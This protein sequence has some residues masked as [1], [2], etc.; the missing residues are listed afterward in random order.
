MTQVITLGWR[1]RLA[2]PTFGIAVLKAKLDTGARSS[3][4]HVENLTVDTENAAT[5]LSFDVRTGRRATAPVVACR[6]LATGRRPVTDSG[7]HATLRW[8]IRTDI[9]IG[10]HRFDID[11]NLT[12]RRHMLFPLLLGRTSLQ[13]RVHVDAGRSYTTGLRPLPVPL[14]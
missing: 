10:G 6:A 5:W 13:G 12:D 9:E 7:G 3:A 1:E 4:L 8:F 14:G 2:M 11:L